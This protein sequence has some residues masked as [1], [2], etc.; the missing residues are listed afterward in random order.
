MSH[1]HASWFVTLV[2]ESKAE[3]FDADAFARA[4]LADAARFGIVAEVYLAAPLRE[5]HE[6][7]DLLT[8]FRHEGPLPAEL[9]LT[10]AAT[11]DPKV[12]SYVHRNEVAGS[13]PL[14]DAPRSTGLLLGL[15]DCGDMDRIDEFHRFYDENHAADVIRSPFYDRGDRYQRVDGELGGF[16]ALYATSMG[17]PAAFRTYLAWPE[18]DR[19]RTEVFVVRSV[20]TFSRIA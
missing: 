10:P 11:R 2:F 6:G 5:P 19:S 4:R 20:G 7:P 14:E 1:L 17:E 15:T 12:G 18:R 8:L 9:E 16:L 13:T 3:G